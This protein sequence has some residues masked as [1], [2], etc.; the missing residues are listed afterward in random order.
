MTN[1]E[2]LDFRRESDTLPPR[3]YHPRRV[4]MNAFVLSISTEPSAA[5]FGRRQVIADSDR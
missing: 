2:T 5:R 3:S 1:I 4:A